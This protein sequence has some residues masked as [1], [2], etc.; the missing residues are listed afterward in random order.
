MEEKTPCRLH[1]LA[2]KWPV[3]GSI[4]RLPTARREQ[5]LQ[6]YLWGHGRYRQTAPKVRQVQHSNYSVRAYSFN[7]VVPTQMVPIHDATHGRGA[8]DL[9]LRLDSLLVDFTTI[10]TSSSP[11]CL[12]NKNGTSCTCQLRSSPTSQASHHTAE[13][14]GRGALFTQGQIAGTIRSRIRSF[15]YAP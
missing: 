8:S 1:L 5:H 11:S 6:N 14:L 12:T 15:C 7:R 9:A 4:H 2:L 13:R 3:A 10:H